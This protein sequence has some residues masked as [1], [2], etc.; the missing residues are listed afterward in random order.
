MVPKN[1]QYR[2]GKE[3]LKPGTQMSKTMTLKF[4]KEN[5]PLKIKFKINFYSSSTQEEVGS[6]SLTKAKNPHATE[7]NVLHSQSASWHSSCHA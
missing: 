7:N 2:D 3:H 6:D 4:S 5:L 1:D